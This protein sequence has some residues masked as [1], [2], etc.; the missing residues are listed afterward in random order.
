MPQS[1]QLWG[2]RFQIGKETVA[3]VGVPATRVM[4][5]NPDGTLTRSRA[6]REH[7]FAVGR[8]DNVLD[9]TNGPIEAAGSVGMPM[10]SDEI[11]ELLAISVQ[12]TPTPTTPTGATAGR[13]WVFKP[14]GAVDSATLEYDDGARQ[15]RGLGVKGNNLTIQGAVNDTNMVSCDLFA[16]DVAINALT[17]ALSERVPT[18]ME[19]WQTLIYVDAFGAAP[20]TTQIPSFLY[21]WN[22]PLGNQLGRLQ[23]AGNTLA[24]NRITSGELQASG[25]FTVDAFSAQAA[26]EFANWDAGTKRTVRL[27][28]LGP[29][30]GIEAAINEVQTITVTGTPTGG[31]FVISVLGQPATILF[32]STNAQAQTAINAA[33]AVFGTGYTVTV[34][35]GP[36]PG[37]PLTVTFDGAGVAGRNI[38]QMS[39]VTN[40]LTGGTTPTATFGTTTAGYYGGKLVQI[41]IPGAWT[42]VNLGGSNDGVRTY[43]LTFAAVY[44]PTTLAAMIAYTCLNNR[45]TLF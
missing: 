23:L 20:G 6:P 42:A 45:T 37:T 33:L 3:G 41:D 44:E 22:I 30:A 40:A 38:P 29:R 1:G 31:N 35:S 5:F 15:W 9:Y 10:S 43:E 13:Q 18:F 4:Y 27:E 25:T 26:T 24:T 19:G 7:R 16:T 17:G 36:L 34:T 39:L 8:R 28:F 12:A 2:T 32:N 14:G 11:M 21:N